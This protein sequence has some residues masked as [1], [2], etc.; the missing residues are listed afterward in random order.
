MSDEQSDEFSFIWSSAIFYK[1]K[2][3]YLVQA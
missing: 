1:P 2:F 3:K